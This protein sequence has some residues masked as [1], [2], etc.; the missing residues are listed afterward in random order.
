MKTNRVAVPCLVLSI[1]ALAGPVL[2]AQESRPSPVAIKTGDPRDEEMYSRTDRLMKQLEATITDVAGASETV[3]RSKQI[4]ERLQGRAK[5]GEDQKSVVQATQELY[6]EL[7]QT[8]SE[9]Q[10]RSGQVLGSRS[11]LLADLRAVRERVKVAREA[12]PPNDEE[13][14]EYEQL[15]SRA[16]ANL[17]RAEELFDGLTSKQRRI[18]DA[19]LK[20]LRQ[21]SKLNL[22]VCVQLRLED[23]LKKLEDLNTKMDEVL[24]VLIPES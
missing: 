7:Y 5:G 23:L 14:L 24:R 2:L 10:E 20:V 6:V 8:L 1:V 16:A 13:R 4:I 17:S 18:N 19:K 9:M 15:E 21:I 12:L 22:M 11:V 3:A